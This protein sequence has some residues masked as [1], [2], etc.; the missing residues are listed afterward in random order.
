MLSEKEKVSLLEVQT[1]MSKQVIR[2][3]KKNQI[4]ATTDIKSGENELKNS[5]QMV[6]SIEQKS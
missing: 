4:F 2:R 5:T 6:D 3:G 1:K